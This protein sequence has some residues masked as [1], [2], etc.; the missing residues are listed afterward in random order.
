[1][2]RKEDAVAVFWGVDSWTPATETFGKQTL[3]EIVATTTNR[4]PT[5]WGRYISKDK[6]LTKAEAEYLWSQGC[7]VLPVFNELDQGQI[8]SYGPKDFK[9]GQDAANLAITRA[10]DP[11]LN[12]PAGV[13]IYAN[14]DVGFFPSPDWILGWWDRMLNSKY[15]GVGG[16]YCDPTYALKKDGDRY[17]PFHH[18]YCEALSRAPKRGD[19]SR[20]MWPYRQPK[21]PDID[22]NTLAW[23]ALNPRCDPGVAGVWQYAIHALKRPNQFEVDYDLATFTAWTRMWHAPGRFLEDNRFVP[24]D[25]PDAEI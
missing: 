10:Q 4:L 19:A 7:F 14:I 21:R 15:G 1:M 16:L 23:D 24:D 25:P 8:N 11:S 3:W 6:H 17:W 9:N 22:P 20:H 12:I 5:F 13:V 18:A 2:L